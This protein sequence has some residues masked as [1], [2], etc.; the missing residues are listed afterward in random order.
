MQVSRK[1]HKGKQTVNKQ[2][3]SVAIKYIGFTGYQVKKEKTLLQS[4]SFHILMKTTCSKPSDIK[5]ET[6]GTWKHC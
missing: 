4:F 2:E 6:M 3:S 1:L 5:H